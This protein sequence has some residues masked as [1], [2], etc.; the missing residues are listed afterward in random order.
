M[1]GKQT[2]THA[3]RKGGRKRQYSNAAIIDALREAEGNQCHAA[4]LLGCNRNTVW[5]RIQDEPEVRAAYDEI[6]ESTADE[7]EGNFIALCKDRNHPDHFKAMQF[8][9]RTKAGRRGWSE[10][11]AIT[12][13]DGGPVN[14]NIEWVDVDAEG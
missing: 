8:Y 5:D 11:L 7:I 6:N 10:S 1:A 2:L 3:K 9:L 13:R 4:R 12:G 14:V